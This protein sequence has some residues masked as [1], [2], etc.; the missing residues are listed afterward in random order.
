MFSKS[1]AVTHLGPQFSQGSLP[2]C[3]R[4]GNMDIDF[5]CFLIY[6]IVGM[7]SVFVLLSYCVSEGFMDV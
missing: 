2:V 3:C 4:D 6:A 7:L 5:N 1:S